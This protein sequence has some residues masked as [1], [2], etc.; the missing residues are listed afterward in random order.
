MKIEIMVFGIGV[1][2]FTPIAVIYGLLS[3]W[4][5]VGTVGLFLLVGLS[6]LV[7]G[8]LWI[9][10]RR[11]DERP[12]DNPQALIEEGAGEQG[13]FSPH[14]WWPLPLAL[15]AAVVFTGLVIGWWMVYVG[16]VMGAV[17]L[18]GWVYEYYRGAHA[19]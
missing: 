11:M 12:E 6:A 2:F 10:S 3:S 18:V 13:E 17:S 4:E 19:H 7:A 1:F 8:Y 5:P 14:S 15:A 9:T 16:M